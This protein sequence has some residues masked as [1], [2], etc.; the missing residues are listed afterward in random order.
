MKKQGKSDSDLMKLELKV[1]DLIS[2]IGQ[3]KYQQ[4]SDLLDSLHRRILM[5]EQRNND[6]SYSYSHEHT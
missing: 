2:K 4:S 5:L 1:K 3:D 6:N